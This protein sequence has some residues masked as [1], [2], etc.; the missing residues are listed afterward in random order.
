MRKYYLFWKMKREERT[1]LAGTVPNVLS[2]RILYKKQD[3][4]LNVKRCSKE[5]NNE[6]DGIK[7]SD[8]IS[9]TS[10][11]THEREKASSVLGR[12]SQVSITSSAHL[13]LEAERKA[14]LAHAASLKE[15]QEI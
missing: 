14:L 1:S 7:P 13:R 4:I 10:S 15:R 9:E 6:D 3:W 12:T 2:L 5:E 11:H 8:S